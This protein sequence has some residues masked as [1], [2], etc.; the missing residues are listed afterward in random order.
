MAYQR[1]GERRSDR[2]PRFDRPERRDRGGG[3]DRDR[4]E[5]FESRD[6]FEVRDR[7]GRGGGRFAGAPGG[8]TDEAAMSLRLDPR[9]VQ[10][11]KQIAGESGMRPGELVLRWV[12]ERIDAE[13]AGAGRALPAAEPGAMGP[14]PSPV[15]DQLAELAARIDALTSRVDELASGA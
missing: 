11:L 12:Q 3:G 9:R 4:G 7:Q 5:R 1:R 13:R 10:L 15:G 14:L 2:P 6:R 8:R